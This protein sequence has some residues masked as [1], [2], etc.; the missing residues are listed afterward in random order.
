[1]CLNLHVNFNKVF[2]RSFVYLK[3]KQSRCMLGLSE[4]VC[5]KYVVCAL[6]CSEVVGWGD[7]VV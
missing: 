6:C 1:M 5:V 7:G 3:C 2:L 4:F